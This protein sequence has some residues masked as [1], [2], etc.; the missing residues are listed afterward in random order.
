MRLPES[1]TEARPF[2]VV[3]SE[4]FSPHLPTNDKIRNAIG[5]GSEGV[6]GCIE[7]EQ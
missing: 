2:S 5:W 7:V 1:A 6:V 3:V 4:R